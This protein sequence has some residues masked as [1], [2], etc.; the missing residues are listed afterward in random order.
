MTAALAPYQLLPVLGF[1]E[2]Q[3]LRAD[4]EA[5]GVRVPVDVDEDG[6]ILDGHHRSLIA[7]DLGVDCPRRVIAGLSEA[8]KV[9]HALAVNV[10]RR[11]LTRE[12][13][14]ALLAASIKAEPEASDR[15][16][17]RRVG[18]HNE[19]AAA[20]RARLID[21][22]DVTD[23]VT[24]T[25][26]LGRQQP[27]HWR[28]VGTGTSEAR[29]TYLANGGATDYSETEWRPQPS[30]PPA[31]P[32]GGEAVVTEATTHKTTETFTVDRETGEISEP[33]PWQ[34]SPPSPE[35]QADRARQISREAW[36][37][38]LAHHAHFFARL[39]IGTDGAVRQQ[40]R[41]FLPAFAGPFEQV[42]PDVLR[43]AARY[44]TAL[45]DA[46]QQERAA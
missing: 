38:N 7:A 34:P 33:S 9:A 15:E 41:D 10:H 16:H 44:L 14:R 45:A 25:D 39:A 5:H 19:T 37:R 18:A 40:A 21:S 27:A 17:A 31:A 46:W 11:T 1:D 20:V 36:S 13:K 6:N 28:P 24:R 26:S 23:S 2:Y 29:G 32:A 12:Q 30:P 8:E 35:A 3:A 22:G 4:I 43:D 42:T